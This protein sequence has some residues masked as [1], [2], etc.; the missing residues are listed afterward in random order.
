MVAR[1]LIMSKYEVCSSRRGLTS[2]RGNC[3]LVEDLESLA[4]YVV[5][6]LDSDRVVSSPP[7]PGEQD[8]YNVLTL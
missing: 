6:P 1:R 4:Q 5:R 8:H 7:S 3:L 2:L